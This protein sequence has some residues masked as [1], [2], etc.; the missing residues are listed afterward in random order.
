MPTT[1]AAARL[2]PMVRTAPL[3]PVALVAEADVEA[4]EDAEL[5]TPKPVLDGRGLVE[6]AT[7]DERELPADELADLDD[8]RV[9]PLMVVDWVADTAPME[10]G[11]LVANMALMLEMSTKVIV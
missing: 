10:K 3:L 1:M 7:C 5:V 8:A 6:M 9:E 2:P 11:A 4:V